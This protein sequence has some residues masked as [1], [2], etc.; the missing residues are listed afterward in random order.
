MKIV[1]PK[2]SLGLQP[3]GTPV[4]EDARSVIEQLNDSLE[5]RDGNTEECMLSLYESKEDIEMP[6]LILVDQ[7]HTK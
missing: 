7:D 6:Q 4:E 3:G 2:D 1:P 5:L